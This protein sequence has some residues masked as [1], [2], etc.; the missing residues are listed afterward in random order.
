MVRKREAS[1]GV[2]ARRFYNFAYMRLRGL[3]D[4]TYRAY[5]LLRPHNPW[6]TGRPF[7]WMVK[8]AG[9]FW[10]VGNKVEVLTYL[11]R[12]FA[13]AGFNDIPLERCE[14]LVREFYV[15]DK[16][17][18]ENMLW[19]YRDPEETLMLMQEHKENVL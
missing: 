10:P 16:I 19:T 18:Y 17:K 14:Q 1:T 2:R 13:D 7:K 11:Q 9:L 8:Y 3:N 5:D 15:Y 6:V 4:I 12:H